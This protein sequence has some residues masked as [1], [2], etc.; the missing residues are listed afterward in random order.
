MLSSGGDVSNAGVR[1]T[2]AGGATSNWCDAPMA[3]Q[4]ASCH[5]PIRPLAAVRAQAPAPASSRRALA[6]RAHLVQVSWTEIPGSKVRFTSIMHIAFELAMV[7]V[8]YSSGAWVVAGPQ[9]TGK[10]L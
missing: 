1:V 3:V 6:R 8:G 2:S 10:R 7:R 9:Q 4:T 5:Q